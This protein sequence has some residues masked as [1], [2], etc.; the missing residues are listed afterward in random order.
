MN[1]SGAVSRQCAAT[2]SRSPSPPL[3][4]PFTIFRR[5]ISTRQACRCA[6]PSFTPGG[7]P[8][9]GFSSDAEIRG[10]C[11]IGVHVHVDDRLARLAGT[12]ALGNAGANVETREPTSGQHPYGETS[13]GACVQCIGTLK[14]G[15]SDVL[16][17]QKGWYRYGVVRKVGTSRSPDVRRPDHRNLT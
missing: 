12:R 15:C 13:F 10:V 3:T 6:S 2:A 17:E 8:V 16:G 5:F 1:R 7:L 9:A 4:T 11:R 14:S